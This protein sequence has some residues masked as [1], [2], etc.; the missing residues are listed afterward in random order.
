[1]DLAIRFENVHGGRLYVKL[2]A[3]T[4]IPCFALTLLARFW[5]E[6]TWPSVWFLALTLCALAQGPFTI[7]AS[8]LMFSE[9]V[10]ARGVLS[11]FARRLPAFSLALFSTR[12]ALALGIVTIVF[13]PYTLALC[14]HIHEIV[15]LEG[16]GAWES[17]SRAQR[18]I[19]NDVRRTVETSMSQLGILVTGMLIG[20]SLGHGVVAFLLQLGEPFG[21]LYDGGSPYALFGFFAVTPLVATARFLGYIDARTRRDGWDLQVRFMALVARTEEQKA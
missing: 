4:V 3:V 13:A 11:A 16:S 15:L 9:S 6:W 19:R 20:E 21:S 14:T 8:R 7:A 17:V 12:C 1:V 10:T 18:F 5:L 2:A